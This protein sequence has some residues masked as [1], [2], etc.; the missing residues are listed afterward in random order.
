MLEGLPDIANKTSFVRRNNIRYSWDSVWLG[1][2]PE[3]LSGWN[4][5]Q[6]WEKDHSQLEEN[7]VWK[8]CLFISQLHQLPNKRC[9]LSFSVCFDRSKPPNNSNNQLPKWER[10]FWEDC[11]IAIP[12]HSLHKDHFLVTMGTHAKPEGWLQHLWK[13]LSKKSLNTQSGGSVHIYHITEQKCVC[14]DKY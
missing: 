1:K 8:T 5:I 4:T 12:L 7:E 13:N 14:R 2:E 10:S 6:S 3:R 9:Q 11:V